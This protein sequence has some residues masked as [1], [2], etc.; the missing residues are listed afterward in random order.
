[1]MFEAPRWMRGPARYEDGWVEI[2]RAEAE[3]YDLMT[4]GD[5]AF[6]DFVAIDGAEDA[7]QFAQ[8]YGLLRQGPDSG[9]LRESFI[10]WKEEIDHLAAALGRY[11]LLL[12]AAT[13]KK[14][15][16]DALWGLQ[17]TIASVFEQDAATDEELMAQVTMIIGGDVS[18]GL[19]NS[20][21]AL[22][23]LVEYE[24]GALPGLFAFAPR[25]PHLLAHVYYLF[26]LLLLEH[27][28]LDMCTH[29]LRYFPRIDARQ[30]YC[31]PECSQRRRWRTWD[32]K[33]R[34]GRRRK[35]K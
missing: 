24:E 6:F 9:E 19:L 23:G 10:V 35:Q 25:S 12:R 32:E 11:Y 15:A 13:G 27:K 26:A 34:H 5:E 1:M 31:S 28:P 4:V 33:H 16:L 17:D 14:G 8:H 29:C 20:P 7:V 21:L 30:R 22:R 3:T 2:N 18:A